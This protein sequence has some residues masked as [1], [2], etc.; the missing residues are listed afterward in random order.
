MMRSTWFA[1]GLYT[2]DYYQFPKPP[3]KGKGWRVH[4]A[5]VRGGFPFSSERYK[6][7]TYLAKVVVIEAAG[8]VMAVKAHEL[9][10]ASILALHAQ[11]PFSWLSPGWKP[12]LHPTARIGRGW[13]DKDTLSF[14]R[15]HRSTTHD[16]PLACLVAC[17]ASRRLR[18]VYALEKLRLSLETFSLPFVDLDPSHGGYL[19]RSRI[20][21]DHVCF[22]NAVLLAHAC[23]EELGLEVRASA[24]NPSRLPSG[25]WNP[26]VRQDLEGRLREARINLSERI[27]WNLRGPRAKIELDR[28]PR[29]VQP[30][31]WSNWFVRDGEMEVIDAIAYVDWL[32]DRVA[33]HRSQKTRLRALSVYDV[34]NAQH[35]ARRLLLEKLGF[36]R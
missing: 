3:Y 29:I 33:A 32:R 25:D 30:E 28:A 6:G 23:I 1:A 12:G 14:L 27:S 17:R 8:Q 7:R 15:R 18:T 11:D 5:S 31:P 13:P 10:H 4:F 36:W 16:F 20:P 19:P 2:S 22:S 35:L 9:I 34:A 21:R 24:A 26:P